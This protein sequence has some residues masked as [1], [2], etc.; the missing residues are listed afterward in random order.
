MRERGEVCAVEFT[1]LLRW[2]WPP[3]PIVGASPEAIVVLRAPGEG[4][5]S[6][7]HGALPAG[8]ALLVVPRLPLRAGTGR[9]DHQRLLACAAAERAGRE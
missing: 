7:L 8:F 3:T 4:A 9:V 2:Y 5:T 6:A 1:S